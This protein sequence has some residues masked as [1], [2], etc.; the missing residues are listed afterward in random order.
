MSDDLDTPTTNCFGPYTEHPVAALFPLMRDVDDL[1]YSQLVDDIRNDGLL[2]PIV[3]DDKVLLDGRNR[4]LA[5]IEAKVTPRFVQFTTL[6]LMI[7]A[8]QYAFE[9][10]H[11]R[12]HLTLDQRTVATAAFMRF[13]EAEVKRLQAEAGKLGGRP[14]KENPMTK[15]SEGYSRPKPAKTTRAKVAETARVSEHKAQQAINLVQHGTPEQFNAVRS[16]KT[17]LKD[18]VAKPKQPDPV[19]FVPDNSENEFANAPDR[20]VERAKTQGKPLPVES[21]DLAAVLNELQT[22]TQSNTPAPRRIADLVVHLV[23]VIDQEV[24]RLADAMIPER[25][26]HFA[27]T[28]AKCELERRDYILMRKGMTALLVEADFRLLLNALHP[29]RAPNTEKLAECFRI[30]SKLQPYVYA[31]KRP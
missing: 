9:V 6:D 13:D 19:A 7:P 15:T 29:D 18:A 14:T 16:G 22:R 4:Y 1:G 2:Q 5:C 23:Q 25:V 28:V 11:T 24:N 31:A 26:A 3:L 17:K 12:R 20:G 8:H 10:N 21:L 27:Q 30:I